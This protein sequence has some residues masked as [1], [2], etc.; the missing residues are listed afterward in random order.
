MNNFGQSEFSQLCD[1]ALKSGITHSRLI[2]EVHQA[3][4]ARLREKKPELPVGI[5]VL[6]DET[7]GLVRIFSGAKDITPKEFM[8]ELNQ[9][10]RQTILK[11][12][13]TNQTS[14]EP[15]IVAKPK[16]AGVLGKILFWGYN[17]YFILFNILVFSSRF[18]SEDRTGFWET[19]KTLGLAKIIISLVIFCLPISTIL[20]VFKKRI[21]F[22]P[23]DLMQIFYLF[24]VPLGLFLIAS[25]SLVGRTTWFVNLT[26]IAL[27]SIPFLLY[28]HFSELNIN[29]TFRKI[30]LPVNYLTAIL[31]SYLTVI[32]T[33]LLSI[34]LDIFGN[35]FSYSYYSSS[36]ELIFSTTLLLLGIGLSLIP[37][38]LSFV[39]W[40]MAINNE[41][42]LAQSIGKVEAERHFLISLI[43]AITVIS[44]SFIRLPEN[45]LITKLKTFSLK[46]DYATQEKVV[47]SL[48]DQEEKLRNLI[49]KKIE[50]GQFYLFEKGS[51]SEFFDYLAYPLVNS[52]GYNDTYALQTNF[53]YIFGYPYTSKPAEKK[54]T[55]SE[56]VLMTYRHIRVYP[57]NNGLFAKIN[58]EE[59][60]KN[61]AWGQQ[62]VIYEFN[63]PS[64]AVIT[65]LKLGPDLEFPGI[66]APKGAAQRTY[67]AELR[68]NRDPA[69]LEQTGPN[70]YRLRV[71]PI[72]SRDDNETLKGK[73]QKVSFSYVVAWDNGYA[74]PVYT[75]K[76][77]IISDASSSVVVEKDGKTINQKADAAKI[78]TNDS[79]TLNLCSSQANS[80]GL[81][82][83][84][85]TAE[86]IFHANNAKLKTLACGRPS[87]WFAEMQDYRTAI[88]YDTSIKNKQNKQLESLKKLLDNQKDLLDKMT[89]DFYKFNNSLGQKERLTKN[90]INELLKP[91]YFF[92]ETNVSV[93]SAIK[94]QY[95]LVILIVNKD[96]PIAK[97]D[98]FPFAVPTRVYL[99]SDESVPP[100]NI[101]MTNGFWQNYGGVTGSVEEAFKSFLLKVNTSKII[102][103]NSVTFDKYWSIKYNTPAQEI[104]GALSDQTNDL[105]KVVNKG[106]LINFVINQSREIT[107]DISI[108]DQLN[109]AAKQAGIVSPYSSA[110][111][112]VN[113]QQ[114][115]RLEN[116]SNE[117]DRYQDEPE[118]QRNEPPI[119]FTT[120]RSSFGL[121]SVP[122]FNLMPTANSFERV[123]TFEFSNV[124]KQII[125]IAFT[126][127]IFLGGFVSFLIKAVR[128]KN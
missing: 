53:Q 43:L 54:E 108:M 24:E 12:V 41:H 80:L 19:I 45:K 128:K 20:F 96:A 103:A 52:D 104:M 9:I 97:E 47:L 39:L 117:Y 29:D 90:N 49:T 66:I 73:R 57:E 42:K 109:M 1:L 63:L 101:E 34:N 99:V 6:V 4:L 44:I 113:E 48:S 98:N 120:P 15:E 123:Q 38:L 25:L 59:E 89:I 78:E 58:I 118:I 83:G 125:F 124:L 35:G 121:D 55:S 112:L 75:K 81:A 82:T 56:N 111:A 115:E 87:E 10:A 69:L 5:A 62:E 46:S 33:A 40:K 86:L 107:G 105:A 17:A 76:T 85:G 28:L 37:Y 84:N 106:A 61:T 110:I 93:L 14:V 116:E 127:I 126:V 36:F 2:S 16:S 18:I 94:E 3:V 79:N 92:D 64:S 22:K 67:E 71:F 13:S 95:D 122:E 72:P 51:I 60:Y 114:I 11:I 91:V 8:E 100:F 50:G 7:T 31:V 30:I 32:F 21:H 77:N 26:L 23:D 65:D 102:G 70:Q 119:I 74:L 68:R 88:V 27:L